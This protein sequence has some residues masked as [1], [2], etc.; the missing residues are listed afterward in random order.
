M[1]KNAKNGSDVQ[2]EQ[3]SGASGC[4][5]PYIQAQWLGYRAFESA[6]NVKRSLYAPILVQLKKKGDALKHTIETET[7]FNQENERTLQESNVTL[8]KDIY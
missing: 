2:S 6:F 7:P 4:E 5:I 8:L 1:I 3:V